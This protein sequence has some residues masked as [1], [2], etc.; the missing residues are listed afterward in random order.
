M[1]NQNF[2]QAARHT[3]KLEA[4]SKRQ[5]SHNAEEIAVEGTEE[6]KLALEVADILDELNMLLHLLEKQADVLASTQGQ[7]QRFKP[8]VRSHGPEEGQRIEILRSSLGDVHISNS[9]NI[10]GRLLFDEV[11]MAHLYVDNQDGTAPGE[12]ALGGN[13][14]ILVQEA[15]QR[16]SVEKANLERLRVDAARTHQMVCRPFPENR[17]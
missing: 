3:E 15:A 2:F 13:A 4:F 7:L 5:S 12:L 11:S 6:L 8:L 14:G 1:A 9:G 17:H 10:R 16:L